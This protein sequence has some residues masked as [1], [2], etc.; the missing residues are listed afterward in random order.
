MNQVISTLRCLLPCVLVA[1]AAC[2]PL[3]S[4]HAEY[5]A[6]RAR[7]A[8]PAG[9]WEDLGA[10]DQAVRLLPEPEGSIA[11][12]TRTVALRG[13]R[14]ELLAVL[15]VQAN[16]TND[17]Q[18]PMLWPGNCPPQEGVVVEDASKGSRV[19]VDCLRFKRW[20][21]GPQWLE[22][23][24]PGLAQWLAGRKLALS[25]PYSYMSYRYAAESGAMV[26][27]DVLAD[28]RLLSPKTRNN[29]EFLAAG[30]PALQWGHDLAQAVR[31]SAAMMDGYLAIPPFPFAVS[32]P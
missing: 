2:A 13:A 32:T 26:A 4:Q 29:E 30:K 23:N 5:P 11:L 18:G 28:Q 9:A 7:L 21:V 24:Q 6:G 20:V 12:Q 8:L 16:R 3:P 17:W 10:D 14:Q 31:V 22:K 1:L 25:P 27:V 15:R 19:R